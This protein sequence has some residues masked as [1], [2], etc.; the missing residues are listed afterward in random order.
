MPTTPPDASTPAEKP[1]GVPELPDRRESCLP[2]VPTPVV[3]FRP[4]PIPDEPVIFPSPDIARQ[5]ARQSETL[6]GAGDRPALDFE[7][8]DSI[9]DTH[10]LAETD[11]G[12]LIWRGCI[13]WTAVMRHLCG[14]QGW[15]P[16]RVRS[17][18]PSGLLAALEASLAGGGDDTTPTGAIPREGRCPRR[19]P[20]LPQLAKA[21]SA[22]S[23]AGAAARDPPLGVGPGGG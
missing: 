6:P 2:P 14:R 11:R 22:P 16:D 4:S 5:V 15:T 1:H 3:P 9:C 8:I 7:E 17:L 12:V 23:A 20:P 18:S 10:R 21:C 13:R 19:H